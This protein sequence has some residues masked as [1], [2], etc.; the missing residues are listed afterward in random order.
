MNPYNRSAQILS[1]N[2]APTPMGAPSPGPMHSTT[3]SN[4]YNNT[5]KMLNYNRKDKSK[6]GLFTD[7]GFDPNGD[8]ELVA[9]GKRLGMG[10]FPGMASGVG[11]F[12]ELEPLRQS[13]IKSA[14][15]VLDPRADTQAK[16]DAERNRNEAL[17]QHEMGIAASQLAEQGYGSGA[18]ASAQQGIQQQ[19]QEATMDYQDMLNDPEYIQQAMMAYLSMIEQGQQLPGFEEFLAMQ[20]GASNWTLGRKQLQQQGQGGIMSG[21]GGLLGGAASAY[22]GGTGP[23]KRK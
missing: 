16:I 6:N 1:T 2:R 10:M 12:N 15:R 4:P 9:M 17:A 18:I 11:F 20:S 22:F 13:G 23:F 21:V 19:G 7:Y 5:G 3:G 8:N 14:L